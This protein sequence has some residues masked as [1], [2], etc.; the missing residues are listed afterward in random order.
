MLNNPLSSDGVSLALS[1]MGTSQILLQIYANALITQPQV[2]LTS[3]PSFPADQATASQAASATLS[4]GSALLL[5]S[6]ADAL[7]FSNQVAQM[8]GLLGELAAVLDNPATAPS[9]WSVAAASFSQGLGLL[10]QNATTAQRTAD[11]GRADFATL[12]SALEM[13][14][15]ALSGDLLVAEQALGQQEIQQ[16]RAQLAA[17]QS[18]IDSDNALLAKGATTGLVSSVKVGLSIV[19]GF[20]KGAEDGIEMFVGGIQGIVESSQAQQQAMADLN[21]QIA[22]YQQVFTQLAVD[23]VALGVVQNE[24]AT[25]QL[26]L[27]H[28]QEG[29]LSLQTAR[30]A[31][32]AL[33]TKMGNLQ[34]ALAGPPSAALGLGSA[35]SQATVGWSAVHEAVLLIQGLASLPVEQISL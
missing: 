17:I 12:A 2:S 21:A 23:E 11:N 27:A 25:L 31:W 22:A 5:S 14:G 34:A 6:V 30:D 7:G 29:G 35:V 16:L 8:A 28:T 15:V 19:V 9:D 13:A 26:L 20:Y 32:S 4:Q 1:G 3:V 33:I 24:A 10:I 18:A